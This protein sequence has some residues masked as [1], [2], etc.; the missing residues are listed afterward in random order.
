MH[1]F[2][3]GSNRGA[4][5]FVQRKTRSAMI[6]PRHVLDECMHEKEEEGEKVKKKEKENNVSEKEVRS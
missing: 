3:I 1:L 5:P 6:S 2:R 4:Q